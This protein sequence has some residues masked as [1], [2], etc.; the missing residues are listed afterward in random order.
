MTLSDSVRTVALVVACVPL[1]LL[2]GCPQDQSA[3][4]GKTSAQTTAPAITQASSTTAS[5][6]GQ[7]AS[8]T[9]QS[10]DSSARAFKVQRLINSAE[11]AYRSGVDNY[12][13]GRLD[14]ARLDFDSAVDLMLTSGMD[15]KADPQLADEFDH[16]LNAVNSLEMAALKQGN[17]FSPKIEEA[18]LDSA[19]DLTFP[20]NPELTAKLKAELQISSDLPLVI[21]DQVAGYIGYFANSPSFHAHMLRSME[22][23]GKYKTMIQ[24]ALTAQGV[25]QD[26]IYLAVA[27]SGFQPQVLNAK[28]GAGGMWQFMPTGAYGLARNGYF[29]ERFDPEKSSIAYARYMKTLY[30]Q[31]GDWYL[32]M[33][34]YD[35]GP[36]NVQ[37]AVQRT[38]YADFWE[39]YRRNA[40]PKETRDYVPKILAAVIMAKNPEKYGLDKMV[41]DEPVVS[42]T[43]SVDYAID[44]RLVADITNSSLPEIVAL[45]PSLLRMTTPGDMPFDLHIPIGTHDVFTERLKEIPQDKRSTWRFHVVRT[46]ESLD[47]IVTSLHA[48]LSDV[49]AANGL[50]ANDGVDTGDELVIPVTVAA[51]TR[52]QRYTV[53]HGDTLVTVSDRFGVSVEELRRWNHLSSSAVRPGASLAVAEPVKLAPGT[54]VHGRGSRKRSGS[55]TV[56]TSVHQG[57]AHPSS[58]RAGSKASGSSTTSKPAG[59]KSSHAA[60]PSSGTKTKKKATR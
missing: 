16:L 44:L 12:R 43:V 53:H 58:G 24:S 40:L 10:V 38:G 3:S 60:K 37:R 11:A 28:S 32:A 4:P 36:G 9:E 33:A 13:A 6:S 8:S 49:V 1:V 34:A 55:R 26:L 47:G 14:A 31:F 20:A 56:S 30:N 25:P 29:D 50:S 18:P 27:E 48:H 57:S 5:Q 17:G 46:G 22:R 39:L 21:N 19:E 59:K 52:P 15:L 23:A 2:T 35:W 41:P 7:A 45:N 42:D 51:S 54:H